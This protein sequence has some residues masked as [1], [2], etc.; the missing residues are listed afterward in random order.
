MIYIVTKLAS[1]GR[2]EHCNLMS[3]RKDQSKSYN[4]FVYICLK[5][6]LLRYKGA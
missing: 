4:V 2:I 1:R 6:T 3:R 5:K